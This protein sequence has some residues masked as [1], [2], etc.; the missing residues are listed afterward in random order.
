MVWTVAGPPN[1]TVTVVRLWWPQFK[2]V[3]I[4]DTGCV[5]SL[6]PHTSTVP[7]VLLWWAE[8]RKGA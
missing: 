7:M 3:G 1:L 6:V 8:M 4:P 2:E 5:M